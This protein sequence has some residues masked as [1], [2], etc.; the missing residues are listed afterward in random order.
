[1][2]YPAC[3]RMVA[4]CR[5]A[6]VPFLIHEN[7][8]WQKPMRAVKRLLEQSPIGRPIRA[9]LQFRHVPLDLFNNQPYLFTQPHFALN[10]MGP[11]L[12]DLPRFFFGEPRSLYAREF[13]VHPRF[14]GEDVASIM[15][16]YDQLVCHC[17]LSWRT[18]DY[19]VFI[20]GVS[21]TIQWGN[22]RLL[23]VETDS[24]RTSEPITP[25]PYGWADQRYGFA[26]S[27]IV[28]TNA[29]L[30]AALRGQGPAETTGED[31]LKTMRLVF[32]AQDSA[33]RNEVIKL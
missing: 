11:H 23:T 21:G 26:H 12:L 2:A 8:R 4:A 1:M 3:E 22:D 31:N 33:A 13:K 6:G 15:L 16:D 17:E 10:D 27:S 20:E 18:T 9:H 28:Q 25:Q 29:H 32:A 5:E 24:G 14:L 30:L 19:E 7:Y